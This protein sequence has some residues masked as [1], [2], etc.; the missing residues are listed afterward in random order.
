MEFLDV[1]RRDDATAERCYAG[2][3]ALAA[4]IEQQLLQPDFGFQILL[5]DDERAL[6][7]RV[8]ALA[9]WCSAFLQGF[10]LSTDGEEREMADD[11]RELLEDLAAIGNASLGEPD[12][13]AEND[14]MEVVEYVRVG[15]MTLFE[16][17]RYRG[18]IPPGELH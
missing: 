14:L 8:D 6:A 1:Q 16:V 2:V 11:C 9:G 15:V 12:E 7:E 17:S 10:T 4:D 3:R 18:D 13:G 5:P